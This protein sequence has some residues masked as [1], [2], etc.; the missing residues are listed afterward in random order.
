MDGESCSE[1]LA[2]KGLLLRR[3]TDMCGQ[4][5]SL[6]GLGAGCTAV[7]Q[8]SE[9]APSLVLRSPAKRVGG[10]WEDGGL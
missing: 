9:A 2:Q 1:E 6:P 7:G 4:D 10:A 5:N 8:G 3:P